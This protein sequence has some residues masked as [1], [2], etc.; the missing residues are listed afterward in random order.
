MANDYLLLIVLLNFI[1]LL[2]TCPLYVKHILKLLIIY[3]LIAPFQTNFG[4]G[5]TL[6]YRLV[7]NLELNDW[8]KE[9]NTIGKEKIAQTAIANQ[10]WFIWKIQK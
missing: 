1:Y 8:L 3:P 2:K 10:L 4:I 9:G 6:I 5:G 7:L